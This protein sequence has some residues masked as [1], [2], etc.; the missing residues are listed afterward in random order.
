MKKLYVLVGFLFLTL[1]LP[2]QAQWHGHGVRPYY[3][4][5]G[6]YRSGPGWG[7]FVAPL[8]I[9]GIAGAAIANSRQ[10]D[11]VVLPPPVVDQ[12]PVVVPPGMKLVC[13][14]YQYYN[15][16]NVPYEQR[17]CQVVPE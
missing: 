6:Y 13:T 5:H 10:P 1:V 8:V 15:N 17:V 9:G 7:Y 11:T 14:T 16:R 4:P 3:G 12:P 2:A